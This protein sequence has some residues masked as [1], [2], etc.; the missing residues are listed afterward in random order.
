M[1]FR[2]LFVAAALWL[3][4]PAPAHAAFLIPIVAS[5]LAV[6]TAV[7]TAI[8]TVGSLALSFGLSWL[9][10]KLLT[11]V[12]VG[13]SELDLRVDATIPQSLIV[14]RAVTA[15]SLVY[16][17]TFG[18][19]GKIDNSD[20]IRIFA[21]ADHVCH[22]IVKAYCEDQEVATTAQEGETAGKFYGADAAGR[23]NIVNGYEGKLSI[24][25]Y[26]GTQTAADQ[27]TVGA[28]GSHPDRPWTSAMVGRGRCYAREHAIWDSDVL[29]TPPRWRFIVDGALLYDPRKDTT[30]G[31][32]GAHRF[33]DLSTHEFTSN[34]MVIAYNILRGVRVKN[35]AGTPVHFYGLEAT[36]AANLPL[37]NWF[38]AM[39]E[40]DVVIDG[41][42]QFHGGMEIKLSD[43]PL[44]AVKQ[45]IR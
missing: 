40:C 23:G 30:V 33:D 9:S 32:S 6:S 45:I 3:C 26:L 38:A 7:A 39:N 19:R 35:A 34:L 1:L 36:P 37:D 4:V 20:L 10:S 22:G 44:D 5:A 31:G 15:G 17:E 25:F 13:G 12:P 21:I 28:L 43:E 29:Q 8:V 27:L 2:I 11:D 16:A 41:E 14:G 18:K 24:E 42:P